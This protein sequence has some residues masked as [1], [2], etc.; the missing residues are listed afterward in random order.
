MLTFQNRPDNVSYSALLNLF[1]GISTICATAENPY[2]VAA[3]DI[4]VWKFDEIRQKVDLLASII[5]DQ[6]AIIN[7]VLYESFGKEL[8]AI[9][10]NIE[11]V[12]IIFGEPS[13]QN[14]SL[15]VRRKFPQNEISTEPIIIERKDV[16]W[17]ESYYSNS[18]NRFTKYSNFNS[19]QRHLGT[20]SNPY[21]SCPT[22]KW[23]ISYTVYIYWNQKFQKRIRAIFSVDVDIS[24]F[25]INQCD[26]YAEENNDNVI[27]SFQGSHKCHNISSECVFLPHNGWVSGSYQC[28]C[29]RGYYSSMALPVINGTEVEAAYRGKLL[30]SSVNFDLLYTFKKCQPG[31]DECINDDPCLSSYNWMF[32]ISLLTICIICILL[33]FLLI[34]YVYTY[35]KLKI[36]KVS[37]PIFL[38]ITLIGAII[39]YSEMAAIF[40]VLDRYSCIATKWTRNLGFCVTYS[41][42]LLKTW[43]VSLTYRVKSAHKLKLTDKQLLQW[44]F[45][46]LL[47]IVIY[48]ST[49]TLSTPPRAIYLK[50]WDNLKFKQCEYGWWDH[51]LA[52]GEFLFLLWGIKVCYNVRKAESFFN[53]SKYISYAIYNIALVNLVMV[54]L[55]L[56]FIPNATP[57]MKYLF[58]FIRTQLSTTITIILI[59]GPKV[60]EI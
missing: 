47:V 56:V 12:R 48:L 46:I 19:S 35:R 29:R 8:L 54:G 30:T 45:P 43:R 25:D 6:D 39:M 59:F 23:L 15:K 55:H 44:L 38:Y 7:K 28:V 4:D 34:G 52:I 31:C 21:R 9:V 13:K 22:E 42:L 37:S 58:G 10:P 14:F 51:S 18:E 5:N 33:T 2:P 16:P 24:N 26:N 57:D 1:D 41:A 32:R 11:E 49:W 53:E 27:T 3:F 17:I 50:D 40:P 60:S 36:I 20:W